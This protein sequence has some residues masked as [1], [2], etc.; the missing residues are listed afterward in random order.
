[1]DLNRRRLRWPVLAL[2][3]VMA[4]ELLAESGRLALC[5]MATASVPVD[6]C[7]QERATLGQLAAKAYLVV[8]TVTSIGV[9]E[10]GMPPPSANSATPCG[11]A[12]VLVDGR[13]EP[14]LERKP[15]GR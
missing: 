13:G 9:M 14:G 2:A 5:T 12:V 7:R 11:S 4:A 1:M 10:E 8:Q 3:T 15:P 6:W